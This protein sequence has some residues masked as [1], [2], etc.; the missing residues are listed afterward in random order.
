MSEKIED[1]FF[2]LIFTIIHDARDL[3]FFIIVHTKGSY[4]I[5]INLYIK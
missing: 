4:T 3:V 1:I 5:I 2:V